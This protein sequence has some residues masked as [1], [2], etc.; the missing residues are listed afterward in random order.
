M[1]YIKKLLYSEGI[2]LMEGAERKLEISQFFF[3]PFTEA[4]RGFRVTMSLSTVSAS[5]LQD[6]YP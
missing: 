6:L 4:T 3:I 2:F 1:V 5:L